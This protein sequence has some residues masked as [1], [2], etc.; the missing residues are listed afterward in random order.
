M[1]AQQGSQESSAKL[2]SLLIIVA[3]RNLHATGASLASCVTVHFHKNIVGSLRWQQLPQLKGATL[4]MRSAWQPLV[5]FT[6][7]CLGTLSDSAF[8]PSVITV[9]PRG[10]LSCPFCS[11]QFA[12]LLSLLFSSVC[13]AHH[14]A[15][16]ARS[17]FS[18]LDIPVLQQRLPLSAALCLLLTLAATT[19]QAA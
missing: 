3:K 1:T 10:W 13:F 14:C 7:H 16:F 19:V 17:T 15:V 12:L 18:Q 6:L 9:V 4:L 2:G 8:R 11:P 5:W